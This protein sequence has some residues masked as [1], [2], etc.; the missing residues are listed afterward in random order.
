MSKNEPIPSFYEK[1]LVLR[2]CG[3]SKMGLVP[4]NERIISLIELH[5]GPHFHPQNLFKIL[6]L[7]GEGKRLNFI[8]DLYFI[9][10]KMIHKEARLQRL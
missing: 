6:L 1:F 2:I 8:N 3:E 10:W 5:N 7:N 4:Q 9:D